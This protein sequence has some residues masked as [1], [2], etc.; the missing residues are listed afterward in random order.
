MLLLARFLLLAVVLIA[1]PA[2]AQDAAD[3]AL[4]KFSASGFAEV[5]QGIFALAGSGLPTAQA[6]LEAMADGRLLV[7]ASDKAVF[8][9]AADG[10]ILDARTGAVAKVQ[11]SAL[12]PVRIN[13]RL[14]RAVEQAMGSLTMMSPDPAKRLESAQSVFRSRDVTALEPLDAAAVAL[15]R[16]WRLTPR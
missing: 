10:S 13:N 7:R 8:V 16:A 15:A 4:A 1:A 6:V 2:R 11:G 14:R 9:K 5:E 12:K 3:A